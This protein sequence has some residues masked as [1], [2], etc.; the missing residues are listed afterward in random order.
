LML[1]SL[2]PIHWL[3]FRWRSIPDVDR[4]QAT[5]SMALP[6]WKRKERCWILGWGC[7]WHQRTRSKEPA[8]VGDPKKKSELTVLKLGSKVGVLEAIC[9]NT[10]MSFASDDPQNSSRSRPA[11]PGETVNLK[12]SGHPG[13]GCRGCHQG[14]PEK[15]G[16]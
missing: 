2:W 10:K 7:F 8:R 16:G 11:P 6:V 4:V 14:L 15:I 3:T 9:L 5:N 13:L 1:K 12:K